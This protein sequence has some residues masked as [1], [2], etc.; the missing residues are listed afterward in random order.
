MC[1]IIYSDSHLSHHDRALMTPELLIRFS[2]Q[3]INKAF[4]KLASDGTDQPE[5][6]A[7]QKE[8]GASVDVTL[9]KPFLF[10]VFEKQSRAMLFLGRVVNP[11]H[12]DLN[13][14]TED[15]KGVE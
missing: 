6:P 11:L 13:A 8:D 3:V 12:E 4:F 15:K 7:A 2:F 1:F 9:N 14:N 5:E 10:S